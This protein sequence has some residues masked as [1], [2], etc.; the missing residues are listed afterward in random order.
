MALVPNINYLQSSD[1]K[2]LT[3]LDE[4]NWGASGVDINDY[5]RT[6]QLYDGKDG[7]GTLIDTLTFTGSL[8]SVDYAVTVDRYYSA[9]YSAING[10]TAATKTVNF[11]TT[12]IE[13][14]LL[15]ELTSK[16]CGCGNKAQDDKVRYGFIYLKLAEK[17]LLFGKVAQFNQNITTSNT[18]LTR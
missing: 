3:L 14:K 6:V 9:V 11:A 15:N 10:G 1:G 18:W 4:S 17:A 8:L 2:T 12:N 16:G 5:T 7:S 13:Y